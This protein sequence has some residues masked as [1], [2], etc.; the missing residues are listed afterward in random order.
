MKA[1][2]CWI[3]TLEDA[4]MAIEAK[5]DFIG[6]ILSKKSNKYLPSILL[7]QSNLTAA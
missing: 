6:L 5:A 4:L 3:T 2:I 1:K 7:L